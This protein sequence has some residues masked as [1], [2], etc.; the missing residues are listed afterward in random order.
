MNLREHMRE[1]MNIIIK[2]RQTT[3]PEILHELGFNPSRFLSMRNT[4]NLIIKILEDDNRIETWYEGKHLRFIIP[5]GEKPL[6]RWN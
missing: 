2:L 3:A 4:L 6:V 1:I 5:Y